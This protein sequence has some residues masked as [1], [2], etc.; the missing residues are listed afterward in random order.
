MS[1]GLNRHAGPSAWPLAIKYSESNGTV[2][3]KHIIYSEALA[4]T[5]VMRKNARW[6]S[7]SQTYNTR[8]SVLASSLGL[9]RTGPVRLNSEQRGN[10]ED[11]L[12]LGFEELK[13]ELR[14]VQGACSCVCP[15]RLQKLTR[16]YP[17]CSTCSR[18]CHLAID[19]SSIPVL[20]HHTLTTI[21]GTHYLRR[22][23]LPPQLLSLRDHIPGMPQ[24]RPCT[25]RAELCGLALQ[26]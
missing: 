24:H 22:P 25:Y 5:A 21:Y 4:V 9:R 16:L 12:M 23:F 1:A 19:H 2:S 7:S 20:R 15:S 8:D 26:V 6:A 13:R 10:S 18:H 3:P 11:D 14:N 17:T